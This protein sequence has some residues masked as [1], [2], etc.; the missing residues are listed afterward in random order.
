MNDGKKWTLTM[1]GGE[2]RGEVVSANKHWSNG[3]PVAGQQ[4][5][6]GYD[7]IGNRKTTDH[8]SWVADYTANQLNQYTERTVPGVVDVMGTAEGVVN[9][10]GWPAMKQGNYFYAGL[11]VDN[12]ATSV[13]TEVDIAS[14]QQQAGPSGEDVVDEESGNAF[15][16]ETPEQFEYDEDGNLVRDGRWEYA[17]DCENRLVSME[18]RDDLA[19]ATPRKRLEFAY[20]YQ[21]RRTGKKIYDWDTDHWSLVTE[22]SFVYDGWNL[23]QELVTD[24]GSLVTN[25]YIWG[26]D[27]SGSLQGA[28]GVGG[29]LAVSLDSTEYF[30]SCDGNGNITEYLDENGMTVAHREYDPFGVTVVSTGDKKNDFEYWFSTKYADE[31]TGLLYYGYRYLN[32]SLGRWLSRD[33]IGEWGGE[34]MYGFVE[35][36]PANRIDPLGLT[37][38]DVRV[39]RIENYLA[40]GA[41]D[42]AADEAYFL[43]LNLSMGGA[44]GSPF[45]AEMMDHWLGN[46]EAKKTLTPSR[47]ESLVKDTEVSKQFYAF[48]K[49]KVPATGG[50]LSKECTSV[51]PKVNTG[52]YYALGT[53]K[54]CFSGTCCPP[55]S[56]TSITLDG[57]WEVEDKYDWHA[58]LYV[59]VLGT[60]IKDDYALLVEGIGKAKS[61]DVDGSWK[62]KH[63]VP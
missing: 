4:Y 41:T 23:I 36:D 14:V 45:A 21:G 30:P 56:A 49:G 60:V 2:E 29:L 35:N 59:T 11:G 46:T 27:L 63:M 62:G 51:T 28:G 9:V 55:K 16:P 12:S 34:N 47:V 38:L 25:S 37:P 40:I 61:Y 17:W 7:P 54:L 5:G 8:G 18:T 24:N 20:D 50:S 52:N 3:M 31:E 58:G 42:M 53:F 10:N 26:L 33:K 39:K 22:H 43:Y 32:T 44:L 48:I 13:F 19:N 15:V 57:D 1:S 6:Y